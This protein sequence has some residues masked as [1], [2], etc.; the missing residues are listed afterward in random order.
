M[1]DIDA[2]AE[3]RDE[4]YS[5]QLPNG[6]RL[7][8]SEELA[9]LASPDQRLDSFEIEHV[10]VQQ[11]RS[12][13]TATFDCVL[14]GDFEGQ[15]STIAYAATLVFGKRRGRWLALESRLASAAASQQRRPKTLA[16]RVAESAR[17]S[18]RKI[19]PSFQD[20]AYIPYKPGSDFALRRT[21]VQGSRPIPPP[22]LWLG[23]DYTAHGKLHVD[24]MLRAVEASGLQW[25]A[26]DRIL[27][28]G[29]GAGR[30]I[31]HLEPLAATCEIWGTDISAEHIFWC[32]ENLSPPF[33][34]ATTTKVPHLPFEDRSFRLIYCGSV[35]T[36]ID[37]LA[38]AWLLE[39]HR[40]LEPGG[41]LYVTIHWVRSRPVYRDAKESFEVMTI[42]RDSDAQVF[43]DRDYFCR[44]LR[45]CFEVISIHPE[46]YFY[47]TAIVAGRPA[48][49]G[50]I[51]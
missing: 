10:R 21:D 23:Y 16:A 44:M 37:E 24:T 8:K 26:G 18:L 27:D 3:L 51:R 49:K 30:M 28:F 29:C 32:K 50:L 47:Q 38:D 12:K 34:F 4:N 19:H 46:A 45:Q 20:L 42:N 43:Y 22:D 35:F 5:V 48:V 9:L 17:S 40:I 39:L 1:K 31:R 41:R 14:E 7:S 15:H 13:A 6:K 11:T 2:A 36:H 25:Q 33:R